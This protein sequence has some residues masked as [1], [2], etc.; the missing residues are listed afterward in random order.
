M[1]NQ[2]LVMVVVTHNLINIINAE[3]NIIREIN[4]ISE[5]ERIHILKFDLLTCSMTATEMDV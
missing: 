5:K 1:H 2:G 3:K 4:V